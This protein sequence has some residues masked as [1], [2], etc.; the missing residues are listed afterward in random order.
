[1][2]QHGCMGTETI[3]NSPRINERTRMLVSDLCMVIR[4]AQNYLPK[5]PLL[6]MMCKIE[7]IK[8]RKQ[9]SWLA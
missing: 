9:E 4:P 6:E 2:D 8:T 5:D 7:G 1:M 3:N